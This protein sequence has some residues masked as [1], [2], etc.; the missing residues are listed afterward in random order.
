MLISLNGRDFMPGDL[1]QEFHNRLVEFLVE[2]KGKDF[3]SS[4]LCKVTCNVHNFNHIKK[5]LHESIGLK[6][7]SSHH[8]AP[9]LRTEYKI[10]LCLYAKHELHQHRAGRVIDKKDDLTH[11]FMKGVAKLAG[12]KLRKWIADCDAS[13][14]QPF[15]QSTAPI[16][17]PAVPGDLGPSQEEESDEVC[18]PVCT[19]LGNMVS[20]EN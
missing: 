16:H 12:G 6:K 14:R 2:C 7:W 20:V 18:L 8:T 1:L 10:L 5:E 13:R 19:T 11:R 3:D 9:H 4:F 17:T 15:N